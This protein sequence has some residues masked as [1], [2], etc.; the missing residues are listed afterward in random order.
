M[1]K[2]SMKRIREE[3]LHGLKVSKSRELHEAVYALVM[4]YL[5]K[6]YEEHVRQT[7]AKPLETDPKL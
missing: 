5:Y 7:C 4:A 3:V 6:Q 1:T 2:Q